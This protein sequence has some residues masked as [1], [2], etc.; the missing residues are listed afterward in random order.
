MS[1]FK[2]NDKCSW[3]GLIGRI[4]SIS[5]DPKSE[6]PIMFKVGYDHYDKFIPFTLDGRYS[7]EHTEPSLKLIERPGEIPQPQLI[8]LRNFVM[9]KMYAYI[10]SETIS[11]S[12]SY[13]SLMWHD[14]ENITDDQGFFTYVRIPSEDKE[15]KVPC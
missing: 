14:K 1:T 8:K 6:Y 12:T 13:S 3:L 5:D 10:Q 11:D 4:V 2:K 7:T 9:K 15:I